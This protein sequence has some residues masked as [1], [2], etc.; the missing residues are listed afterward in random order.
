MVNQLSS[1]G[2]R[3]RECAVCGSPVA[4]ACPPQAGFSLCKPQRN[5]DPASELKELSHSYTLGLLDSW[6][7]GLLDSYFQ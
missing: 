3:P 7:L 1:E 6:T 4:Q 2:R 5:R